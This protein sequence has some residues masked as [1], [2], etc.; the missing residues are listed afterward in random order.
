[1]VRPGTPGP[2]KERETWLILGVEQLTSRAWPRSD[3]VHP[4]AEIRQEKEGL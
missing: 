3:I 1:M 2:E 4:G